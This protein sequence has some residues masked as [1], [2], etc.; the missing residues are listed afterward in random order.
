MLTK[1]PCK[2]SPLHEQ[3]IKR[4]PASSQRG[5]TVKHNAR[6][7]HSGLHLQVEAVTP[8]KKHLQMKGND[9]HYTDFYLMKGLYKAAL[10]CRAAAWSKYHIAVTQRKEE[11]PTSSKDYYDTH[12]PGVSR[13]FSAA[14][15]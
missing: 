1:L 8:S 6:S 14:Y 11:E 5:S 2:F 15:V 12:S 9:P 4:V 7:N 10:A 13:F 3:A